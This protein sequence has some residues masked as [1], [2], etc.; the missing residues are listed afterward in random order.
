MILRQVQSAAKP[1]IGHEAGRANHPGDL[2]L[3]PYRIILHYEPSPRVPICFC[4]F[5]EVRD[6]VY[7]TFLAILRAEGAL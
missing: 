4:D 7:E 2:K 1:Q 6:V 3:P 5:A